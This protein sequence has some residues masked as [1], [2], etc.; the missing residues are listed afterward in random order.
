M[1]SIASLPAIEAMRRRPGMYVGSV[2]A[3]GVATLILEVVSNAFDQYLMGRCHRIHIDVED[4]L[5]SICDDGPGIPLVDGDA[6]PFLETVLTR[7]HESATADSHMPHVHLGMGCG[8]AAVNALSAEFEVRV[9]RDGAA[10]LLRY[11]CGVSTGPM[12]R[13]STD[14]P[15]GTTVR[16]RPDPVIFTATRP[17]RGALS[18]QLEE[19][20]LLA[21]GLELTW[22][23]G[24]DRRAEQGLA[25]LI[26]MHGDRLAAPAI[27]A[28]ARHAEIDV[29][30][31][32]A[33][34]SDADA[35]PRISSFVNFRRTHSH[36]TH[37]D[38][39][40]AG[41][42]TLWPRDGGTGS[43]ALRR[44]LVAGVSVILPD[45]RYGQPTRS[46]LLNTEA[47]TAVA[48]VTRNALQAWSLAH[49]DHAARIVA[50][51]R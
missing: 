21:P 33:W 29:E 18:T 17:L 23:F 11:R 26:E 38:G 47:R 44:G 12:E 2:D 49:P 40:L 27:H 15:T 5:V 48:A 16:F 10:H 9:V 22:S 6:R 50:A 7:V 20:A 32:I 28:R 51:R 39:L 37:V 4:D 34:R 24:A 30:I 41:L 1:T 42:R 19:L 3:T 8:L 36:G 14:E 35:D 13:T 31:A 43:R 46:E 25:R 45:V